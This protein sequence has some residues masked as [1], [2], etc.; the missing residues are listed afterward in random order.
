MAGKKAVAADTSWQDR[1]ITEKVELDEK[2]DKL[3]EF[4]G[5]PVFAETS[6][7]EQNLLV[8]QKEV[9]QDYSRVLDQRIATFQH[10]V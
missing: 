10:G 8:R 5:G 4:I 3:V 7:Y 1:V 6:P 9:M 2:I